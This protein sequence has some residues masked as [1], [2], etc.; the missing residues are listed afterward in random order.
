M[1]DVIPGS[2]LEAAYGGPVGLEYAIRA[3]TCFF[4]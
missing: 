2:A 4:R 1:V 3:V